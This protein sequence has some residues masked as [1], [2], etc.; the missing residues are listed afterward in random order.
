MTDRKHKINVFSFMACTANARRRPNLLVHVIGAFFPASVLSL[1]VSSLFHVNH[2]LTNI[3]VIYPVLLLLFPVLLIRH[4]IPRI[5]TFYLLTFFSLWVMLVFLSV[6]SIHA[7]S[8]I[9]LF[10][11]L[12][13]VV[14]YHVSFL[15]FYHKPESIVVIWLYAA[16]ATLS[17]L[18]LANIVNP[19]I[20][21]SPF[22]VTFIRYKGLTGPNSHGFIATVNII[23]LM[24]LLS[25]VKRP[26]LRSALL[27]GISYGLANLWAT[28]SRLSMLTTLVF[29]FVYLLSI[30]KP[31]RRFLLLLVLL[32]FS[33]C[34]VLYLRANEA[35]WIKSLLRL[36]EYSIRMR[37]QPISWALGKAFQKSFWPYGL[38]TLAEEARMQYLDS[39]YLYLLLELGI[40]GLALLL[41]FLTLTIKHGVGLVSQTLMGSTERLLSG[42]A[43]AA[44]IAMALHG[45]GETVL[46]V[47]IQLVSLLFWVTAAFLE[48]T[49]YRMKKLIFQCEN[50]MNSD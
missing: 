20:G 10:S 35:E 45:I 24:S 2:S 9:R 40:P 4:R 38:G 19:Y 34:F 46:F 32:S 50:T 43:F 42:A 44:F 37:L 47:G 17:V 39:S 8:V 1:V 31:L 30:G 7:D 27:I 29:V 49:F 5:G 14:Y 36:D 11:L 13:Q 21:F 23:A 33:I 26:F 15:C 48:A 22:Y 16:C 25:V 3:V 18:L 41:G 6:S 12:L 28:G